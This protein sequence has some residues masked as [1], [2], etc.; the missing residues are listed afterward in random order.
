MAMIDNPILDTQQLGALLKHYRGA[1]N[2]E[3]IEA[4]TASD[5]GRPRLLTKTISK[6]ETNNQ[7]GKSTLAT[8]FEYINALDTVMILRKRTGG[9]ASKPIR[10]PE[11]LANELDTRLRKGDETAKLKASPENE[12]LAAK[13][14]EKLT[15][16]PATSTIE[17]FLLALSVSGMEMAILPSAE[18]AGTEI[19]TDW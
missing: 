16:N 7:A 2:Q 12:R 5:D 6:L 3:D 19:Q 14:L 8:L 10:S 18:S 9:N 11:E 1:T 4:R 17:S 13:T 15:T